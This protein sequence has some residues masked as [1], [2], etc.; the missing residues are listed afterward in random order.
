MKVMFFPSKALPEMC[1]PR[2]DSLFVPRAF[3]SNGGS[4]MRDDL[5]LV[6]PPFDKEGGS[7]R[8]RGFFLV[9]AFVNQAE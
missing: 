1:S 8:K 7:E 2:H 6:S 5:P 9:N 4:I 3:S